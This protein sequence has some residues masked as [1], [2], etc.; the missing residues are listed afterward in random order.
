MNLQEQNWTNLFDNH[1]LEDT[2]WH[3]TWTQYSLNQEVINTFQ[4]VRTFRTNEDKTLIY[5]TNNYTYSDGSTEEKSWQLEKQICNQPDGLVHKA[6]PSMRALSFGQGASA[7]LSKTLKPET[8]FA[9]ELFFKHNHWRTSVGIIYAENHEIE[10]ITQIR[11]HL[12]SFTVEPP[13]SEVKEIDGQWIGQKQY[14]NPDLSIFDAEAIQ[15]LIL[16]PTKGIN[17]T[18]FLPDAVVV[19]IPEKVKIGKEFQILAGRFVTQSIFKRLTAKYDVFGNFE[20]LI[21]EVFH[22]QFDHK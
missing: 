21:S 14:M 15:E 19:N 5:Q 2:A 6:V 7:W 10:R 12:G 17:K 1:T 22:R 18:V 3:G 8:K 13:G 9:L 11:E 16:D 4:C 20:L